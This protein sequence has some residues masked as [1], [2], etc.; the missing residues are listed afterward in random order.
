[1]IRIY[2]KV[3]SFYISELVIGIIIVIP[4]NF[5]HELFL[6][7]SFMNVLLPYKEMCTLPFSHLVVP[8][9]TS[10]ICLYIGTFLV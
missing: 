2:V 9:D 10:I 7:V 3:G 4:Y 1:M 6:S 5:Q 8:G